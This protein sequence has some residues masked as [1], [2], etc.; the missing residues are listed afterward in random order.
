MNNKYARTT[1]QPLASP[2]WPEVDIQPG[3][4]GCP[5]T[6]QVVQYFTP[7][8]HPSPHHRFHQTGW[9]LHLS[10]TKTAHTQ[11]FFQAACFAT[12]LLAT[13]CTPADLSPHA[14]PT[15]HP[16]ALTPPPQQPRTPGSWPLLR[17]LAHIL[18][19]YLSAVPK[20]GFGACKAGTWG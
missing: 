17:P 14:T 19:A 5:S 3:R 6:H 15:A 13:C 11:Y 7:C 2:P 9:S 1:A 18:V 12:A 8:S 16:T 4:A 10:K 20:A